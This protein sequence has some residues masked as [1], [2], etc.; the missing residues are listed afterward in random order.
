MFCLALK[1]NKSVTHENFEDPRTLTPMD[2]NDSTVYLLIQ[3]FGHMS[4]LLT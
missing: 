2:M 1:C 3:Y 4:Y